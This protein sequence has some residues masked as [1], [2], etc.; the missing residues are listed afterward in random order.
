MEFLINKITPRLKLPE[1]I[2]CQQNDSHD[3]FL[4]F[5]ARGKCEVSVGNNMRKNNKQ[6]EIQPGDYFGEICLIYDCPRTA[7]VQSL[8]YSIFAELT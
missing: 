7:T 1:D 2:L 8:D 6:L 5:I 3:K 4:C